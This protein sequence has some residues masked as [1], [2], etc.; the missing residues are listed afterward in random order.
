LSRDIGDDL[1]QTIQQEKL[2]AEAKM[3][4]KERLQSAT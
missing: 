4:I 3:R 1:P 2:S